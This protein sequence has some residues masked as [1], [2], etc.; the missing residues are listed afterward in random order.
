MNQTLKIGFI[1][2]GNMAT[3]LIGGLANNKVEASFV[4]IEPYE[5]SRLALQEKY[6]L[7]AHSA[8]HSDLADCHVL[9]MAVKPQQFREA[10]Q[11]IAQYVPGRLVISIAAGIRTVDMA[12]WLG[13]HPL[14]VRCMPNTPAL[15]SAGITG[16]YPRPEVNASQKKLADTLLAAVGTT[17]WVDDESQLDAVTAISGSGPAYVFYFIE[18]M[19]RAAVE[20]GLNETAARELSLAT[21]M[22]ASTLATQSDEPASVLRERV[23]SKGGTTYAA[24]SSMNADHVQDAIVRALHAAARR[25][26]EMGDE[27]G[28]D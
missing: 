27:F 16:L 15:I 12:R 1:G 25:S 17:V 20:L 21:F 7:V 19:Q 13:G 22:G 6:G 2:G 23:T 26:A 4:V 18:A 3:A 9:I 11:A 28:K 24:L 10:A 5:A 8:P 14:L